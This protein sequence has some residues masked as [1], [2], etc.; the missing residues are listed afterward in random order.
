[1]NLVVIPFHDWKKCEHE[2]FRTRDA[3]FMQ[4]FGQHPQVTKLLV[5]NRPLSWAEMLILKR[6]RYPQHGHLISQHGGMY[7]SQVGEKTY[8]L[9]IVVPELLRPLRMKRSWIPYIFGKPQIAERVKQALAQLEMDS[10]YNMFLSAPLFV[11]LVQN[12]AP[13]FWAFD[14]QDNLL[15]QAL[16]RHVPDLENF[17]DFCLTNADFI[18]AN[19]AETTQWF[20]GKRPDAQ[21]IPNGVDTDMFS[22]HQTYLRPT[23]LDGITP[24]IIGYAG[25][26]QEMFDVQA[27]TQ[28]MRA[29]PEANFVF[30]G[31][32]LNREWV[33]D[34]WQYPN[35]Y[36]LGD[37]PY[38]LLP[39]YLA[40]F[41]ICIIPYSIE[42]QHG[43]DPIKFYEY[44]S[45]GKPI[46]SADI[47]GVGVFKDYP[48]VCITQTA[49]QFVA[50][51]CQMVALLKDKK[52][53]KAMPVPLEYVWK[54]KAD[55]I[56]Q[57]IYHRRSPVQA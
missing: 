11:P 14:A 53:L 35:A 48:Q 16:Y 28:A 42:R 57:A 21:W 4:E 55:Q 9:D 26:M 5:I 13:E 46:V 8:T 29:L 24:P 38:H 43:G 10:S 32:Q 54:T 56:I 1:M 17:Y 49:E 3:H 47:G 51:L 18:S 40:A 27:I 23:D 22:P 34:I 7:L 12:L 31:Q 44:L 20:H 50:G 30:I 45:M 25:K 2:G 33:K 39:Q 36:Y 41:D 19:S 52:P 6:R 15:K 37:K